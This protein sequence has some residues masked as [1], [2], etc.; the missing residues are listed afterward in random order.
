M[1]KKLAETIVS[2][3]PEFDLISNY[4]GRGCYKDTYGVSIPSFSILIQE[5]IINSEMFNS[6]EE[7]G[8]LRIDNLG[9]NY[10]IY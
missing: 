8:Y 3:N 6:V 7:V 10:I 5:L 4:K 9:M 1:D 2:L